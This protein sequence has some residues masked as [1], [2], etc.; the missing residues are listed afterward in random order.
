MPRV[1]VVASLKPSCMDLLRRSSGLLATEFPLTTSFR[2]RGTVVGQGLLGMLP[3]LDSLLRESITSVEVVVNVVEPLVG[4]MGIWPDS[5]QL[6][7]EPAPERAAAV[8]SSCTALGF[9]LDDGSVGRL[10]VG[11]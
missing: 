11:S 1:T 9:L 5:D 2:T 7:T 6:P 4:E 3:I 10:V 8:A